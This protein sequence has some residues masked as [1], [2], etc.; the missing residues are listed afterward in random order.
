MIV[1]GGVGWRAVAGPGVGEIGALVA[2]GLADVGESDGGGSDAVFAEHR[3]EFHGGEP[4]R[5]AFPPGRF[6]IGPHTVQQFGSGQG[7]VVTECGA[8]V[9]E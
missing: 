3:A 1:L 8:T 7:G 9:G 2:L 6:G 5:S 4:G